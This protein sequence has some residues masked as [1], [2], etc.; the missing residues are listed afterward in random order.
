M[1]SRPSVSI[2]IIGDEI[3]KGQTIDTNSHFLCEELYKCGINVCRVSVIPDDI[4]IIAEEVLKNSE[5]ST[6]VLT[7]GGIG[8]THDD[9]TYDGIAK[10]FNEKLVL[11]KALQKVLISL[12]LSM[13]LD[14]MAAFKMSHVPESAEIHQIYTSGKKPS[15]PVVSIKNV[16]AF[17]GIPLYLEYAFSQLKSIFCNNSAE[18]FCHSLYVDSN[19]FSIMNTLNVAVK[20]FD[21][22]VKFGSYPDVQNDYYQVKLT[23]EADV[24]D[25]VQ[26]A[27][28]YLRSHLPH[29]SV[30]GQFHPSS[31]EALMLL[32]N[33][34]YKEAEDYEAIFAKTVET[35]L[36]VL[37]EC[38]DKYPL[39]SVCLSFNGGKDCTVLLHLTHL[40]LAKFYP[41]RSKALK[42]LYIRPK[43]P[44]DEI[45]EF[46]N[47]CE[48]RYLYLFTL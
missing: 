5:R 48:D 40:Y 21:G 36:K 39:E 22:M 25:S 20:E 45:E 7:S 12:C 26:N 32:E 42:V 30:V 24:E 27:E 14:E 8:P 46:I 11:N 10:A 15:F 16:F 38:F 31:R 6:F 35:S 1:A 19:E 2:I 18:Y 37:E 17:S 41:K 29:N 28:A 34:F 3:L 47:I 4:D 43:D 23:L 9:V 33:V 44:F 13:G